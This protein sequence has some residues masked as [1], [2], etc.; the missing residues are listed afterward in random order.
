MSKDERKEAIESLIHIKEKRDGSLKGR[1]CADGR[2]QRATT[3]KEDA[4]SPTAS[5]DA[6]LLTCVIDAYEEREV[7]TVDI[8]NAFVQTDLDLRNKDGSK[9]KVIMKI[10]GKLADI[11]IQTAPELYEN[12]AVKEK[13]TVVIYVELLKALYGL[14]L[15]AVLF[16]KKLLKDLQAKGFVLNKYDPCVV[17]KVIHGKQCTIVWWV[18]DLKVSHKE[19]EVIDGIMVWLKDKYEDKEIGIMKPTRGKKH[20]FLGML[21]DYGIKGEVKIDMQEYIGKMCKDFEKYMTTSNKKIKTSAAPHLFTVREDAKKLKKGA[22]KFSTIWLREVYLLQSE[23][24]DTF[25]LRY[26]F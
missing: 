19:K 24:V 22:L 21:L 10:T 14:L 3:T 9:K 12:Y 6:I 7:A 8:P 17:N 23:L 4:S 2:P 11:L 13:G 20:E 16:Y 5:L 1:A 26:P 25:I 18:D 15:A